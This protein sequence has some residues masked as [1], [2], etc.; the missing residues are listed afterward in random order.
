MKR[1]LKGHRFGARF[2]ED[3]REPIGESI[4]RALVGPQPENAARTQMG[5]EPVQARR[6]IKGG[7]GRVQQEL[8]RM[9]DIHQDGVEPPG[10]LIRIKAV[11]DWASIHC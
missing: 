3:I 7:V 2:G 5:G 11:L 10:G 4:V 6:L 1:I 8:G 9:V